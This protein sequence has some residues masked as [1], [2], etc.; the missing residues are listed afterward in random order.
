VYNVVTWETLLHQR[1]RPSLA[2]SVPRLKALSA[3]QPKLADWAARYAQAAPEACKRFQ[4]AVEHTTAILNEKINGRLVAAVG[5]L[6]A[7]PSLEEKALLVLL[8]TPIGAVLT[9]QTPSVH[10]LAQSLSREHDRRRAEGKDAEAG[11]AATATGLSGLGD[12]GA[13]PVTV[14]VTVTSALRPFLLSAAEL[15]TV[16]DMLQSEVAAILPVR[17]MMDDLRKKKPATLR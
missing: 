12:G 8:S 5:R 3:T 13:V 16:L 7:F 11:A 17:V 10:L 4:H 2:S 6:A 14:T 9:D 15:R 1:I